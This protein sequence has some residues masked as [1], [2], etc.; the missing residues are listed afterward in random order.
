MATTHNRQ[1][2]KHQRPHFSEKPG[3][4]AIFMSLGFRVRIILANRE[5]TE[6]RFSTALHV[7]FR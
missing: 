4:S 6:T 7:R 2:E 5:A 1:L 3:K